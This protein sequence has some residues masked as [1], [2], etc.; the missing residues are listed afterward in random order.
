M[1]MLF[2]YFTCTD[3]KVQAFFSFVPFT[4]Y[5]KQNEQKIIGVEW[6]M[7]GEE[8]MRARPQEVFTFKWFY[9]VNDTF[10][11]LSTKP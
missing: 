8:R 4:G 5:Q 2:H 9:P 1:I 3:G 6:R 11:Q 10:N 7:R